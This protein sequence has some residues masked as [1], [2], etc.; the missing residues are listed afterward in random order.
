MLVHTCMHE[1]YGYN[2]TALEFQLVNDCLLII[3]VHLSLRHCM[4]LYC[5]SFT[6][7]MITSRGPLPLFL[8]F[9]VHVGWGRGC[10]KA[11]FSIAESH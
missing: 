4:S 1:Y 7:I 5:S 8:G 3:T 10:K 2:I 9:P 6:S 11:D